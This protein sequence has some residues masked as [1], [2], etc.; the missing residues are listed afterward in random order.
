MTA[1]PMALPQSIR[2][3]GLH[4]D[5]QGKLD[6]L[7]RQ[8]RA[9]H[10]RNLTRLSYLDGRN[11]LRDL[12]A[13]LP[14]D[15]V[16]QVDAVLG[17]PTKAVEEL[18]NRIVLDGFRG[19]D[20]NPHGLGDL[21][22]ANSFDVELPQAI[23]STLSQSVSFTTAT[24]D[25]E[26]PAGVLLQFHSAVWSTGLWDRRRRALSAGLVIA[27]ADPLGRPTR[28]LLLVPGEI[29][30]CAASESGWIIEAVTPSRTGRRI[31][32]EM[33]PFQSTLERP[34]GRSR[35]DR[36]VMS[37]TDRAIRAAVRLD[38][39]AELFSAL[40]LI[41]MGADED[42]FSG[43]KWSWLMD[44]MNTISKDEDGDLPRLEKVSAESP[45]PHIAVL[46]Q[47]ASEFSGH[48]GVPL[49]NLGISTQN[50]ESAQ[51]KQEAREDIGGHAERQHKV[52]GA[53]LKRIF[54]TALMIRDG[55]SEAPDLRALA[56]A[57]RPPNRPTLAALA[58]AGAK[59]VGAVPDLASTSVGLEL[60][61]LSPE[62]VQRHLSEKSA[63][64]D[65]LA[66]LAGA[67]G[68]QT[69]GASDA[70]ELKAKFDALGVAVRSGVDPDDAASK[71]GLDGLEFT[72]AVPVSLRV[73]EADAKQLE[74]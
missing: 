72:G 37:V 5:D 6:A 33:L 7:L 35:I 3:M 15:L 21:L 62:Q 1:I 4:E 19:P 48:T 55:L 49:S 26:N 47:L 12:G 58:D 57:W 64:P 27:D 61:G 13:V 39:H 30:T 16:D 73:P 34:F 56:L 63:A 71:L 23:T 45:E 24:P 31:P 18:A 28:L 65:P 74:D 44:R 25:D 29:V 69:S 2:V 20:Q 36:Q 52:F 46:R 10:S 51:A 60:V 8:W 38:I 66:A 9:K 32:M 59:Q 53:A 14:R 41:L 17:W 42:A 40:K 50:V 68:R 43:S 54:G 11:P 22:E 70:A 67:V